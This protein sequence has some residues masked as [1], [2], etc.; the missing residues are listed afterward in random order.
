MGNHMRTGTSR[1]SLLR[2]FRDDEG[3]AILVWATLVFVVLLGLVSLA[4]DGARIMNLNSNLQEIADAAALSGAK[5]LDGRS[6]AITRAEDKAKNYLV[7]NPRWSD[8]AKSGIQ[9]ASVTAYSSLSPLTVATSGKD[10]VYLRVKT[11]NRSTNVFFTTVTQGFVSTNATATARSGFSACAPIQSFM[12]NPF[13]NEAGYTIK[14]GATNWMSKVTPGQQFILAGGSGGSPGNWG[15]IDPP[16][17][18]GHN[19]HDQVAFW[20]EQK[21]ANCALVDP[22]N[23]INYPDPGNNAS[24][25]YPGQNV[26]F[27]TYVSNPKDVDNTSAP[28]VID[29]WAPSS[30]AKCANDVN[31][32]SVKSG[33]TTTYP[34]KQA[35]ADNGATYTSYCNSTN[36]GS[37]P[38]PRD[39][40]YTMFTDDKAFKLS[41]QGGGVHIDDLKAYW[42]NHHSGTLPASFKTRYDVYSCEAKEALKTGDCPEGK[43]TA[44]SEAR[45]SSA[46]KCT[47]KGTADRRLLNVA[48]VDCGYWGVTGSST[49]LPPFTLLAQFFMTERGLSTVALDGTSIAN[50]DQGKVY[51]EL[52]NTFP[53]NSEGSG[54]YQIVQLVE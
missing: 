16:A 25:A 19:P 39:R 54:L 26:R 47:T 37:C 48:I 52:V 43:F 33:S 12:C 38:L 40:T 31:T 46:P 1:V 17:S 11:V 36:K 9:I 18:N 45:E 30:G 5:E 42:A 21:P 3:G 2:Q 28:I 50:G 44:A 22:K 51:A 27:D 34:F 20:A 10:G 8:V 15:L 24:A 13:E 6:D 41:G 35:D 4:L 53:P 49:P 7:N 23:T 29:G 14:G 32:T